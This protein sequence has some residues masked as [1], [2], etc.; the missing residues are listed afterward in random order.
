[1]NLRV[2]CLLFLAI[3]FVAGAQLSILKYLNYSS[4]LLEWVE[5]DTVSAVP[6]PNFQMADIRWDVEYFGTAAELQ[7]FRNF[8]HSECGSLD[9]IKAASCLSE[10][11][12]RRIPFGEP[13]DEMFQAD[14]LPAKS[15]REHLNGKPG[16]CVTYSAMTATSL[17]SVGIPARF[18]QIIPKEKSGHNVIEV[19]DK[20]YGWVVFDPLNDSLISDGKRYMSAAEAH[21]F[22]GSLIAVRVNSEISRSGYLAEN[23]TGEN[24]FDGAITYPEPWLYCRIGN[25]ESVIFRGSFVV[26]GERRFE[27]GT[28]QS[29]LR[30][31]ITICI[32]LSVILLKL[33][34]FRRIQRR[35][36]LRVP[37]W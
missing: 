34:L 26:F 33:A 15:F 32:L 5:P 21:E 30:V 9:G 18:V 22:K 28:F 27:I 3:L 36:G 12:I 16:H 8:F 13:S 2:S 35:K 17:L 14:F 4:S 24:P 20:E 1:M 29:I 11:F 6:N 7:D 19:W 23:Y 10:A 25:K 37:T 31:G